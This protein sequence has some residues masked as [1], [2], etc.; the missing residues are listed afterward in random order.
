MISAPDIDTQFVCW[1]TSISEELAR[2]IIS[3]TKK[4]FSQE[5]GSHLVRDDNLPDIGRGDCRRVLQVM[6]T[7]SRLR[8]EVSKF[9][10]QEIHSLVSY[11]HSNLTHQQVATTISRHFTKVSA[12]LQIEPCDRI[13]R[14]PLSSQ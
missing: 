3:S 10:K 12:V 4:Q 1:P 9:V 7:T 8:M 14:N 5:E 6:L 2:L 11:M 13:I